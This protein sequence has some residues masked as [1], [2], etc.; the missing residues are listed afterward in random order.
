V[1]GADTCI[2]VKGGRTGVRLSHL[3]ASDCR[4]DG[5]AADAASEVA[6]ANA[7]LVG[8]GRAVHAVGVVTVK[9]SLVAAN[10]VALEAEATGRL[11]SAYNDL[12]DNQVD[13]RGVTMGTGNLS[14][15][16]AFADLDRR[17]LR[18][19]APQPSTDK[20]DPADST[21]AEPAPSGERI[22]LGAFGGTAD[23]E[24]S[25]EPSTASSDLAARAHPLADG[26]D[27]D[28]SHPR[29]SQNAAGCS[30]GGPSRA[31]G[32]ASLVASVLP[33]ILT[34]R[35]RRRS[36]RVLSRR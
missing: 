33:F 12:F 18:L 14:T 8:N 27:L 11:V 30:L 21:G 5:I 6:L 16:V 31:D 32:A 4:I 19:L 23:A 13:D 17:D 28:R 20:G 24:P 3:I 10:V 15:A 7:T 22:N 36:R 35:A 2:R 29:S 25:V 34:V 1:K 26:P 9:N